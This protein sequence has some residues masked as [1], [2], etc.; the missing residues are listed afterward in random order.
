[1]ARTKL[2]KRTLC[3]KAGHCEEEPSD[4]HKNF[5]CGPTIAMH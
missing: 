5:T 2:K 4:Y 3:M 1:M